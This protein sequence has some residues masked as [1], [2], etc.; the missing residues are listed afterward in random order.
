MKIAVDKKYKIKVISVVT[1]NKSKTDKLCQ[2]LLKKRNNLIIY[3]CTAHW[4]NLLAEDIPHISITKYV[5]EVRK[6]FRN[7]HQPA[8]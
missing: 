3:G 4:I 5:S 8:A 1:D 6:Y 2:P 7:L